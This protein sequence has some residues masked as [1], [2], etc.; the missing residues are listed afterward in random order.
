MEVKNSD[1]TLR[2]K[3][4]ICFLSEPIVYL[5]VRQL[6]LFLLRIGIFEQRRKCSNNYHNNPKVCINYVV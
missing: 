4:G 3:F 5:G 1:R 2:G 6:L